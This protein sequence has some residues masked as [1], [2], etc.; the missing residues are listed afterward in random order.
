MTLII[1]IT[2]THLL[3][4]SLVYAEQFGKRAVSLVEAKRKA[5]VEFVRCNAR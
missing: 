5:G 2:R 4:P 3:H 1:V